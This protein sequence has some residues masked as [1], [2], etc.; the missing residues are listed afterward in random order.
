MVSDNALRRGWHVVEVGMRQAWP[1]LTFAD[2]VTGRETRV[3]VDAAMRI[4]PD[5]EPMHQDDERLLAALERVNM[6][7]L[8]SAEVVDG[9]LLL[10][11]EESVVWICGDDNELS[12]NAPW[13]ISPQVSSYPC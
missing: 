6:M 8:D 1:F 9:H 13:R 12:T 11:L 3:Y 2:P 10:T 7:T 5:T 4:S